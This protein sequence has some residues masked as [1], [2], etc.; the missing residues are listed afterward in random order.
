GLWHV[1]QRARLPTCAPVGD[2]PL[3]PCGLDDVVQSDL[4]LYLQEDVRFSRWLRVVLGARGDHFEWSVTSTSPNAPPGSPTSRVTRDIVNPKLQT[5]ITPTTGWDLYLDAGGGFH[6]ND[7]RAVVAQNGSGA[8]PRAWG[9]EVGTRLSL[10]D[11]K[12]D[13]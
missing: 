2:S 13:V 4:A 1:K 3:N 12:L 11:R 7:A 5:I 10:L 6:S 8:L 9:G